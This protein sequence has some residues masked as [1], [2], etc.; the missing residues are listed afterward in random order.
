V[1]QGEGPEFKTQYCKKKKKFVFDKPLIRLTNLKR[2]HYKL[3]KSAIEWD[4]FFFLHIDKT[5][6]NSVCG[7]VKELEARIAERIMRSKENQSPALTTFHIAMVIQIVVLVEG[8]T[9]TSR[10]CHR[11]PRTSPHKYSQP[12]FDKGIKAIEWKKHS[13]FNKL[14]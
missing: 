10:E 12:I 3:P 8:Q 6:L 14:C 5:T 13:L 11:E 7:N 9:H 4:F 2:D 1:A